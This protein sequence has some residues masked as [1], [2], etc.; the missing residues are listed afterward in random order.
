MTI[1]MGT[2]FPSESTVVLGMITP[3]E[4]TSLSRG[5]RTPLKVVLEVHVCPL[6]SLLF[7][8]L[9]TMCV[10]EVASNVT[11]LGNLT[12]ILFTLVFG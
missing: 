11:A 10:A 8:S 7:S 3:K 4:S 1:C 2:Y 9:A 12:C 5:S 6:N